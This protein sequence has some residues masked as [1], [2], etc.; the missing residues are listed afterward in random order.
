MSNLP[1]FSSQQ[2]ELIYHSL[3]DGSRIQFSI[4]KHPDSL[5]PAVAC[6]LCGKP[7]E[8]TATGSLAY[9]TQHRGSKSCKRKERARQNAVEVTE[10]QRILQSMV[11][12][13][14]TNSYSNKIKKLLFQV[15]GAISQCR[16]IDTTNF[17]FKQ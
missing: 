2:P 16:F 10:S 7:I 14:F 9:F 11:L 6:D 17:K 4:M 13:V 3:P 12:L 5:K 1:S 8:I 15:Q